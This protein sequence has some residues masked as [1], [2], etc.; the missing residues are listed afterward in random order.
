MRLTHGMQVWRDGLGEGTILDA[1]ERVQVW[2]WRS[3]A[4]TI[5]DPESIELD[6]EANAR[7]AAAILSNQDKRSA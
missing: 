6:Y 2:W 5:E 4:I 7:L 3:Q 1:V